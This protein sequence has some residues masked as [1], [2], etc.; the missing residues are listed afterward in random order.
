MKLTVGQAEQIAESIVFRQDKFKDEELMM[1]VMVVLF[2]CGDRFTDVHCVAG[3][4]SGKK[5]DLE[6]TGGIPKCPNGHVLLESFVRQ[7]LGWVPDVVA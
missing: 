3:E 1:S 4:W 6:S 7:T 5:G 2:N